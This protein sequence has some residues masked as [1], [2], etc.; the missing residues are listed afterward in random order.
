MK[1]LFN[2]CFQ[3]QFQMNMF[4]EKFKVLILGQKMLHLLPLEFSHKNFPQKTGY[5]FMLLL[6][7]NFM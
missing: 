2:A 1:W 3:V 4:R 5:T 7:S 6:N